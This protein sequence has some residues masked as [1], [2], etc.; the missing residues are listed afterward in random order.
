MSIVIETRRT[1]DGLT[2]SIPAGSLSEEQIQRLIDL[3]K[4]EAIVAK[5]QLTQE[6][7]DE[8]AREINRSWWEKNKSRI[9]KM[10]S[11]HE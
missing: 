3:V 6:D 9:E 1:E 4:A 8:I 7:A 5:S 11:E 10:V 2:I